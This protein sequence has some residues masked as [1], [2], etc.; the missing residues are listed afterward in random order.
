MLEGNGFC[1]LGLD[2]QDCFIHCQGNKIL[3][4]EQQHYGVYF[5]L[6]PHADALDDMETMLVPNVDSLEFSY[7]YMDLWHQCQWYNPL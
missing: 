7:K 3:S 4:G 2:S 5:P 1:F 6:F